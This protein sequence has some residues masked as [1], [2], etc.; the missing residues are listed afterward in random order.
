MVSVSKKVSLITFLAAGGIF[1]AIGFVSIIDS[2]IPR[3]VQVSEMIKP[4]QT[5]V[6]TPDMNTGNTA[7]IFF[8][9]ST[10]LVVITDPNNA[11]ILNKTQNNNIFN[12]TIKAEKDGKYKILISNKGKTNLDLNLGA[13]SKASPIAFS[14]QMML[15]ITGVIIVGLGFRMRKQY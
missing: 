8:N 7:N 5:G 13:F 3:F 11:V 15:V 1:I 9:K 2:N 12:E 4:N 14:G 6:F 10:A